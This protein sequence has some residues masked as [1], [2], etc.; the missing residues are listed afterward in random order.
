MIKQREIIRR[1]L[2]SYGQ[3]NVKYVQTLPVEIDGVGPPRKLS[4]FLL[5]IIAV[6][7]KNA[8]TQKPDYTETNDKDNNSAVTMAE[9]QLNM[10]ISALKQI[11]AEGVLNRY[12]F[13][14]SDL[15]R[16]KEEIISNLLQYYSYT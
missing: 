2:K 15:E 9:T 11:Q 16:I 13:D 4:V 3:F 14:E 8:F 7:L 1:Q 6:I 5:Y 12:L 10:L